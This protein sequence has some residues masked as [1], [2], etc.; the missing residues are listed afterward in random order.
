M[1]SELLRSVWLPRTTDSA[2]RLR[3][4]LG[5]LKSP[6][7]T[8]AKPLLGVVHLRPLPSAARGGAP[9]QSV[10]DAALRDGRALA[11]GGVDGILVENFGDAPFHTGTRRDPVPPDVPAALA[12][13]ARELRAATCTIGLPAVSVIR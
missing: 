9:L 13:A 7:H 4:L 10:L 5:V 6:W 12:V 2:A 1:R 11:E 8:M 3:I